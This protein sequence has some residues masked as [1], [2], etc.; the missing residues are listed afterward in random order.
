MRR[1]RERAGIVLMA[2]LFVAVLFS[3]AGAVDGPIS[4]KVMVNNGRLR[5]TP[6]QGK[7]M[8][9]GNGETDLLLTPQTIMKSLAGT[10]IIKIGEAQFI[11]DENDSLAYESEKGLTFRCM[12]GSIEAIS[13]DQTRKL[14]QGEAVALNTVSEGEVSQNTVS[15]A[16]FSGEGSSALFLGP[17]GINTAKTAPGGITP[18]QGGAYNYNLPWQLNYSGSHTATW[19]GVNASPYW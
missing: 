7:D 12:D 8:V 13:G 17:T 19:A 1:R 3:V 4:A 10:C 18:F 16:R 9:Y 2:A 5:L 11:L 14:G 15:S 6:L